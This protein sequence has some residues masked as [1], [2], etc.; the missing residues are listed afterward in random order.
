MPV[1]YITGNKKLYRNCTDRTY[2]TFSFAIPCGQVNIYRVILHQLLVTVITARGQE[3][4]ER[5]VWAVRTVQQWLTSCTAR[6]VQQ[7]RTLSTTRT[8]QQWLTNV[9]NVQQRLTSVRT[10]QP[11]LTKVQNVQQWLILQALRDNNSLHGLLKFQQVD[12]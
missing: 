12:R 10:V 7:W 2:D 11:W 1:N 4:T 3:P 5:R 9:Q 6:I 8:V